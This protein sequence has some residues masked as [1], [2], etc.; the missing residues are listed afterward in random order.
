MRTLLTT[1]PS[2]SAQ[3]PCGTQSDK[4]GSEL[5]SSKQL[6][7]WATLFAWTGFSSTQRIIPN[8]ADACGCD[9]FLLRTYF[10][11]DQ[12]PNPAMWKWSNENPTRI[13]DPTQNE[14]RH[15]DVCRAGMKLVPWP[16]NKWPVK[17]WGKPA[18]GTCWVFLSVGGQAKRCCCKVEC[19]TPSIMSESAQP[20]EHHRPKI[21]SQCISRSHW[22]IC[23]VLPRTSPLRMLPIGRYGLHCAPT[24]GRS[25]REVGWSLERPQTTEI[26][27]PSPR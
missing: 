22:S 4:A 21:V 12:D 11:D 5:L 27:Y 16:A 2:W 3:L 23:Q 10:W 26:C 15:C 1:G 25:E 24:E 20:V 13:A 17:P 19:T 8:N 6:D 18:F 9:L 14:L 7:G